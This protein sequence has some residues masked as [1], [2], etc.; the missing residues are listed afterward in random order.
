MRTLQFSL[1]ALLGLTLF[2]ALGCAALLHATE[3]VAS[4]AYTAVVLL[5]LFAVVRGLFRGPSTRAFWLGFA[6]FGGGYFMGSFSGE[7]ATTKLLDLSWRAIRSAPSG[8]VLPV[9]PFRV[10]QP[11]G[12]PPADDFYP[13][14]GHFATVGHSLFAVILAV[15]GGLLARHFDATRRRL[16]A[17]NDSPGEPGG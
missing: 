8:V 16:L 12:P 15:I 6:V 4:L 7:L 2:V 10:P 5:L 14:R 1:R 13:L 3:L 17:E 11:F 9:G